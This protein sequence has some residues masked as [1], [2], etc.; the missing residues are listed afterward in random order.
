M[1]KKLKSL[2][3]RI[4]ICSAIFILAVFLPIKNIIQL[5]L[6]LIA[7]FVIGADILKKAM[8]EIDNAFEE[9]KLKS[10]SLFHNN[11]TQHK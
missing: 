6:F 11:F 3:L 4:I 2:K 5:I 9:K 8:I 1:N 10:M 7:Y